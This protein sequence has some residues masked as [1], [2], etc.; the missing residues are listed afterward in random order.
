VLVWVLGALVAPVLVS[1]ARAD[2]QVPTVEFAADVPLIMSDGMPCIEASVGDGATVLF[3]IDTG[4]VN[5][6]IDT[7]VARSAGL[8][9]V[10][11]QPPVPADIYRTVIP[12]LHIGPLAFAGRTA[13]VMDFVKNQ[14]PPKM[15]GTLAYT[16]FKDRIL[17]VD[18]RSRRVR[19]SAVL[20]DHV[21][22]PGASDRFSLITFGKSGPPIV[23][24]DGFGINGRPVTAQVDTLYTGSLLVYSASIEKLGLGSAAKTGATEFFPYT[25][26]GVSM[27]VT[28]ADSETFHGIDLGRK[29]YF[30]A[31]GVHEPDS[32]FDA[33]VGLGVLK[34][35]VLTLNFHDGTLSV[36]GSA[37][38]DPEVGAEKTASMHSERG[39]PGGGNP[40]FMRIAAAADFV[41]GTVI[42]F[43]F[44]VFIG[45]P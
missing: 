35:T 41:V 32:L 10:A 25:D 29:L 16:F 9:L 34:D 27:K 18:F 17:Q 14:L 4:D 26:G 42:P 2:S 37:P 19:I 5:S 43:V 8:K 15:G 21:A 30:P 33:T 23:V 20:T 28:G 45:R 7:R 11:L 12:E 44:N 40:T 31:P 6:V 36:Q 3:G 39:C 1:Q 13:V 38:Q 24:A 22:L